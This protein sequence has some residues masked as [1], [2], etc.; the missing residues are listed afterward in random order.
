MPKKEDVSS[1]LITYVIEKNFK[2]GRHNDKLKK[3]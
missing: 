1:K 3:H 2:E